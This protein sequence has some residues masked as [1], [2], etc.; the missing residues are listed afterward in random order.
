MIVKNINGTSPNKCKCGSWLKHWR[1]FC[2]Q[3]AIECRVKGCSRKDLVGA[4]VQKDVSYNNDWYI[5]PFCHEHNSVSGS[6]E[7]VVGTKL[8]FANK[9]LTCE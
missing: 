1:N 3:I 5:V 4:H 2:G 8:V 6:I 7:L 9:S